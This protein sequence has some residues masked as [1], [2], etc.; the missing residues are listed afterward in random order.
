VIEK[1]DNRLIG[2]WVIDLHD[3]NAV[4]KYG[5]VSMQFTE[6]GRLI[7]RNH[8]VGETKISLLS[9]RVQGDMLITNQPSMPREEV[10][11]FEITNEGHLILHYGQSKSRYIRGTIS[12]QPKH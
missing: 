9:Y 6:D 2:E 5:V 10:T 7:Y 1:E 11:K 4:K 8:L 12:L 3:S